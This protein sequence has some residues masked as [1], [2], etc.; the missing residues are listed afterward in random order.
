MT[1]RYDDDMKGQLGAFL[2]ALKD[3]IENNNF[4]RNENDIS[5]KYCKLADICKWPED[6]SGKEDGSDE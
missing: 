5:C 6:E 1:C 2:S 4:P 3:S